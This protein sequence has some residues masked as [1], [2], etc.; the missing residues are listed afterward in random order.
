LQLDAAEEH[1]GLYE[2][3]AFIAFRHMQVI[4][5]TQVNHFVTVSLSRAQDTPWGC[6]YFVMDD[7]L[8]LRPGS[9]Q[10]CFTKCASTAKAADLLKELLCQVPIVLLRRKK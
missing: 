2:L 6:G 5:P 8:Q 1:W 9:W 4:G 3:F 7:V 10:G